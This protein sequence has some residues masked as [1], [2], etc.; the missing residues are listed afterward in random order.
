MQISF[1]YGATILI[2]FLCFTARVYGLDRAAKIDSIK[3]VC[4]TQND[5]IKRADSYER[6][7]R[8]YA[9]SNVDSLLYYAEEALKLAKKNDYQDGIGGALFLISYGYDQIGKWDEAIENLEQAITIFEEIDDTRSLVAAYLNLGVLYSYRTDQIKALEY[10]IKAKNLAETTDSKFGL[11]EALINIG[12]FYEVLKEY[13]S[14]IRYYQEALDLEIGL[15]ATNN[16][17]LSYISIGKLNIK[18]KQLE[19]ALE[20]LK[21]AKS[22]LPGIKDLHRETE[23]LI[24]FAHYYLEVNELEKAD[25]ILAQAHTMIREQ[26]F[27]RLHADEAYLLG[28]LNLKRKNYKRA[29]DYLDDAIAESKKMDR[30]DLLSDIYTDQTEA[31]AQL[32]QYQNAYRAQ[33]LKTELEK[34]IQPNKLAQVLGEFEQ[35]E[36]LKEQRKQQQLQQQLLEEKTRNIEFRERQRTQITIFSLVS[37]IVVIIVFSYYT[38]LRR[39]HNRVLKE[40]YNTI[41]QQKLLLEKNLQQLAENEQKLKKLNATKD[42]F[43][44]IIAHDLRNPFNVMI[45]ISDLLRSDSDIK[46]SEDFGMLIEGI[47][48]AATS[49]YNLL[50]NLL[51]WS[52]TQTGSIQFTPEPFPIAKVLSANQHLFQEAAKSKNITITWPSTSAQVF[53]DYNMVSFILRNLVSNALKFSYNGGKIEV[54]VSRKDN[55]RILCTI[56]DSGTGMSQETIDKLFKIEHSVQYDGTAEEKGTG[57]GLILCKEFVEK[58]GGNIY[59]ESKLNQ[60]SAFSFDLP[61]EKQ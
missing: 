52:R 6:L 54:L 31:Y 45:G 51:E 35:Q 46:D 47:F 2:S 50:E 24:L 49:G 43:F 11:P 41:N 7:A 61:E 33:R 12:G 57:L 15:N 5:E 59:V 42:K 17:S 8:L 4:K 40:N 10:T 44:S 53:A 22:L 56:K 55:K 30:H 21:Q 9:Y 58:N 14:A 34:L 13:R 32:G 39:K 18:L 37:L 16:V 1:K 20:N 36:Q 27:E 23:V 25:S 28:K 60:G 3:T 48:Q 29:L 19:T 38:L 26:K